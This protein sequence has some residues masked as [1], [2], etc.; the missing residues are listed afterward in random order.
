MKKE[1]GKSVLH[2]SNGALLLALSFSTRDQSRQNRI[3]QGI[4]TQNNIHPQVKK[5]NCDRANKGIS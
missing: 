1:K 4:L 2:Q 3:E 5:I